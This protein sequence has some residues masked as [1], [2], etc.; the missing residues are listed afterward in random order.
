MDLSI[1]TYKLWHLGYRIHSGTRRGTR[2]VID[3]A[4][5]V[6]TLTTAQFRTL[7]TQVLA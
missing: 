3:P 5:A 1:A 7:C 6:S 2:R 4:G